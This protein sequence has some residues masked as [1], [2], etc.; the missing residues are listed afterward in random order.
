[1]DKAQQVAQEMNEE[2]V[3]RIKAEE[4][5]KAAEAIARAETVWFE[6]DDQVTLRDGSVRKI[7]PLALG[8]ARRF[9]NLVRT[10]NIDAIILNFAPGADNAEKDLYDIL[11][12]AFRGYP[13]MVTTKEDGTLEPIRDYLDRV[14]DIRMAR[15]LIDAMLD[16]NALKKL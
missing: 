14:I 5:S 8:E 10:V 2:A 15:K 9:M 11:A 12:L 6:D 7:P 3:A 4:K 13:D 16:L 1:M